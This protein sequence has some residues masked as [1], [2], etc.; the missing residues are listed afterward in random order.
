VDLRSGRRE[1]DGLL[2]RIARGGA[3][4]VEAELLRRYRRTTAAGE[5]VPG[6][7]TVADLLDGAARHRAERER[8]EAAARDRDRARQEAERARERE[9]RL[10]R[11]AAEGE[12]AWDRVEALAE[13]GKSGSYDAAADLLTDLRVLAERDG[14]AAEF[15]Q[16]IAGMRD[17]YRRRPAFLRRLSDPGITGRDG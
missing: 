1:K 6:T 14:G 4:A 10:R 13:T 9:Q 16:R 5:E 15:D 17:R 11:L 7:R 12:K 2:L 8:A 3:A